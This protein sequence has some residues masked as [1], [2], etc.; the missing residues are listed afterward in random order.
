[1][2]GRASFKSIEGAAPSYSQTSGRRRYRGVRV[3][4]GRWGYRLLVV[5]DPDG[6]QFFFNYPNEP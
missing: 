2:V 6:N 1:M 4:D 3:K 5:D